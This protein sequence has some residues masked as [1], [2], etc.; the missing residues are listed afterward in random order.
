MFVRAPLALVFVLA[1][2]KMSSCPKTTR[3]SALIGCL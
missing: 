1:N 3:H 2:R